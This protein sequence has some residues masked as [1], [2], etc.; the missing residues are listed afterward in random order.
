VLFYVRR[1]PLTEAGALYSFLWAIV[2]GAAAIIAYREMCGRTAVIA[3]KRAF[4][5]SAR[6]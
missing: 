3:K 4:R 5:L 1:F 2:L 6:A